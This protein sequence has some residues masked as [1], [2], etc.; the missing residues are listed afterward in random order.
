[1]KNSGFLHIYRPNFDSIYN[2]DT[3]MRRNLGA[4]HRFIV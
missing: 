2:Y 4:V 3:Y 1:M